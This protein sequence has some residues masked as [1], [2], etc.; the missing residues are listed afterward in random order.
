MAHRRS[1]RVFTKEFKL[2]ALHEIDAGATI[3]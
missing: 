2:Q 1:R 3:P